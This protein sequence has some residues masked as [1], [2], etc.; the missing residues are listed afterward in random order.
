[1]ILLLFFLVIFIFISV[2]FK[3]GFNRIHN[4]KIKQIFKTFNEK[5]KGLMF[6]KTIGKNEGYLFLY[7]IPSYTSLDEKYFYTS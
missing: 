7:K 3:E 5:K 6:R 2:K 4:I 1:M